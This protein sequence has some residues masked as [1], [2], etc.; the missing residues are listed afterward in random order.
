MLDRLHDY[1]DTKHGGEARDP[2]PPEAP[3]PYTEPRCC[4]SIPE[5]LRDAAGERF[6]GSCGDPL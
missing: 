4:C 5:P 3:R 1:F 6:C 2:L